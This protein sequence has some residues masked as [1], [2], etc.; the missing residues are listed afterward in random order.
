MIS[1]L[2]SE[3]AECGSA[4]T[5]RPNVWN[6]VVASTSKLLECGSSAIAVAR[7]SGATAQSRYVV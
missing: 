7:P 2:G 6:G 3:T 1:G 4:V 5:M